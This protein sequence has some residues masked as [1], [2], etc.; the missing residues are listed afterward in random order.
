MAAS[1][2]A[3]LKDEFSADVELIPSGGGVFE[4]VVDGDLLYS[5]KATGRH[6]EPDEVAGLIRD[7][8]E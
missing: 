8:I 1:L 3:E 6:A 2:A 5:K 7:E 4:V